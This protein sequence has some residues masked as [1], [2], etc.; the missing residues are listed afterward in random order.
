[1]SIKCLVLEKH[2]SS[3]GAKCF[4]QLWQLCCIRRSINEDCVATLV[5]A[6]VASLVDYCVGLL[7]TA[8]QTTTDKLQSIINAAAGIN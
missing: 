1:M 8:P 3:L 5:H 4:F 2:V 7:A 6:F